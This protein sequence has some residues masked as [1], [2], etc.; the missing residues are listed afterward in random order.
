MIKKWLYALLIP[1][2]LLNIP[3]TH[4]NQPTQEPNVDF[5][6]SWYTNGIVI[7]VWN[8]ESEPVY[9]IIIDYFASYGLI[10]FGASFIGYIQKLD[11]YNMGYLITPIFGFGR[12]FVTATVSYDYQEET[13]TKTLYGYFRVI[14]SRTLLL[15]EW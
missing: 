12:C 1:L 14:G 9:N 13:Y 4:G 5:N 7:I 11:S 8:G 6:F 10:F 2:L 15:Q 3:I